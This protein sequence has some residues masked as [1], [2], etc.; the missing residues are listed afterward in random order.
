VP[1]VRADVVGRRARGGPRVVA[2]QRGRRLLRSVRLRGRS[3][4]ALNGRL[5]CEAFASLD[6]GT[7]PGRG[8][9]PLSSAFCCQ[10]CVDPSGMVAPSRFLACC[11]NSSLVTPRAPSKSASLTFAPLRS[12]PLRSAPLRLVPLR[13]T[14]GAPSP[15][16]CTSSA[17]TKNCITAVLWL[18]SNPISTDRVRARASVRTSLPSSDSRKFAWSTRLLI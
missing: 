15:A 13:S 18:E 6:S 12:A 10:G 14:M 16:L 17:Y 3:M 7:S 2:E 8:T 9:S 5:I 4:K 11:S 1:R